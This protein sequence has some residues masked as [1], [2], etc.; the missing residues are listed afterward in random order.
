MPAE[1]FLEG[2]GRAL[3]MSDGAVLRRKLYRFLL[4]LED[5]YILKAEY[6][7]PEGYLRS[8]AEVVSCLAELEQNT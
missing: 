3:D 2:Y 4:L 7:D 1:P 6:R 8:K 5:T